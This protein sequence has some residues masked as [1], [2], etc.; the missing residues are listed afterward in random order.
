MEKYV[1]STIRCTDRVCRH[2][3]ILARRSTMLIQDGRV[4]KYLP[5]MPQVI[6]QPVVSVTSPL[7]Q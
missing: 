2:R 1:G 7:V 5:C 4:L 6:R 3:Y